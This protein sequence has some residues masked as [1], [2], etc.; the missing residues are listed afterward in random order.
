M[1]SSKG[2]K[3]IHAV[4]AEHGVP[5]SEEYEFAD[6]ISTSGR[7]LRF[8]FA[9]FDDDGSLDFL[10]EYQGRQHYESVKHFGG[11]K[12]IQRQKYN[13]SIKRAYCVKKHI[14]LVIVGTIAFIPIR[15]INLLLMGVCKLCHSTSF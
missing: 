6:L 3:R 14:N 5:F 7:H 12:A 11:D 2:E 15:K 4:L 1:L 10:I 13:D 8:D 9:V